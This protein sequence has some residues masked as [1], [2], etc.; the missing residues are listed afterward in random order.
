M[1][2]LYII[3]GLLLLLFLISLIRVEVFAGYA[4]TLSLTL[5]ILFYKKKLLP[6]PEKPKKK[7]E[8]KEQKPKEPEPEKKKEPKEKK[9]NYL[10]RLKE[11]K[12]LTGLLSLLAGLAEIAAGALRELFSHIVIHKL[13][14]GIALSSG[15]ASSTAV[16]YGKLCSIVYPA[17]DV[18][19]NATVC[20]SYNVTLE[21]VFDDEKQTEIT[22][23]LHAHLRVIFALAAAAKAGVRLLILR[24]KL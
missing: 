6:A 19:V 7:P 11:K 24:I 20:K 5:K 14:V 4:D 22:A 8:K 17:V 9:P 13:N 23:D 15:D 16:N 3:L 12:G 1:I 10:S 21:P 18:I 2:A